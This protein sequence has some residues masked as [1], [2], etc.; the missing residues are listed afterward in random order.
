MALIGRQTTIQ[1][2]DLEPEL[3]TQKDYQSDIL[4]ELTQIRNENLEYNRLEVYVLELEQIMRIRMIVDL[5]DLG[6]RLNS[7]TLLQMCYRLVNQE[8]DLENLRNFRD[9]QFAQEE[10]RR[11]RLREIGQRI[12]NR[13]EQ[14]QEE[15]AGN[16]EGSEAGEVL[17][18][19]VFIL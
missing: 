6:G 15:A 14:Q 1:M 10:Q 3:P 12:F 2:I 17:L 16:R 5:L 7:E 9:S 19:L 8:T 4:R 18:I 11:D 13:F